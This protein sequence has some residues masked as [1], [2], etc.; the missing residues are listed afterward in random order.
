V[1]DRSDALRSVFVEEA[2]IPQRHVLPQLPMAMNVVDLSATYSPTTAYEQWSAERNLRTLSPLLRPFDSTLVRIGERHLVWRLAAHRLIADTRSMLLIYLRTAEAYNALLEGA[3]D[4]LPM[5]PAYEDYVPFE[6]GRT[7]SAM[8]AAVLSSHKPTARPAIPVPFAGERYVMDLGA[9][10]TKALRKAASELEA[11][12]VEN[13]AALF[14]VCAAPLAALL[15]EQRSCRTIMIDTELDRRHTGPWQETIGRISRPCSLTLAAEEGDTPCKMLA[16][17]VESWQRV[18]QQVQ[19]VPIGER[20]AG[21]CRAL[22]HVDDTTFPN[23]AGIPAKVERF[24]VCYSQRKPRDIKAASTMP[25]ICLQIDSFGSDKNFKA[26]FTYCSGETAT[27]YG[28]EAGDRY[29]R[30]LDMLL[31]ACEQ[32]L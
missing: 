22:L 2:G 18:H 4:V 28:P 26:I 15:V 1:V 20:P 24:D 10:R 21:A 29:L 7:A 11:R 6:R 25:G 12:G 8:E 23:F 19:I 3:A 5:L 32:P 30:L 16:K 17:L 13:K 14:I 27:R 9:E 31:Q